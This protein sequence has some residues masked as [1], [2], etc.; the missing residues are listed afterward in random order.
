M[1]LL[2][3]II[4]LL[5][6]YGFNV[7]A[8]DLNGNTV[9]HRLFE[10]KADAPCQMWTNQEGRICNADWFMEGINLKVIRYVFDTCLGSNEAV[11]L[12]NK[13]GETVMDMLNQR[14]ER[15]VPFLEVMGTEEAAERCKNEFDEMKLLLKVASEPV[16][17]RK[18]KKRRRKK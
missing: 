15:F 6:K 3:L 1:T 4:K 5:E 11:N 18:K 14:K 16:D 10:L 2:N 12:A 17:D 9:L 13:R 8:Q 7:T